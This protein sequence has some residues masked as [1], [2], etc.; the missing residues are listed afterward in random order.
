MMVLSLHTELYTLAAVQSAA[1]A[2]ASRATIT[3]EP[4]GDYHRVTIAGVE[5]AAAEQVGG[6]LA[7]Y[8]LAA[9]LAGAAD[10][11][12]TDAATPSVD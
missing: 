11:G 10:A 5:G 2:F 8:A 12:G 1:E 9:T 7:N 3:V 6:E 4:A